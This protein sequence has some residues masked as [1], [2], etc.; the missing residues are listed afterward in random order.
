[1]RQTCGVTID[2]YQQHDAIGLAEFV[3]RGAVTPTELL[4]LAV[5]RKE[6]VNSA[7]NAVSTSLTDF[8][9]QAINTGLPSGPFHGV[10]LLLKDQVDL[11]GQPTRRA[12]KLLTETVPHQDS[13]V[14][15]RL[16][17]AGFVIF[18]KTNMPELGLSVTTEPK[19]TGPTLNPWNRE[20]SPGGSSGG[21]AAAVAAG[22]CPAATGTDGGGSIR[23]PAS[24]CAV[25]GLKP[26][27]GR[28]PYGPDHGEGWGGM[29]SHGVVSRS[30]RDTAAMLD[31]LSGPAIGDPYYLESTPGTF[32]HATRM[33]PGKLRIGV[34]IDPPSG[35]LVGK[36]CRDAVDD[37]VRLLEGLGHET[38]PTRYP[39][40]GAELRDAAGTIIRTKVFEGLEQLAD[41]RGT[42]LARD[43]VEAA[44]WMIHSAGK[45]TSGRTYAEAI[46]TIHRIGR[47]MGEFMERYD[48]ILSPTLAEPP[49]KLGILNSETTDGRALFDRMREFSP[50]C[51]LFN[52]T[53]QPA[54]SVPLYWG[55]KNLPIGVQFAGKFG[56]EV[57][58][59]KLA[60]QLEA[61]RPWWQRYQWLRLD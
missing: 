24:C 13:T 49:I 41:Q 40:G 36:E 34:V 2:E 11:V 20:F 50:F 1:V 48:V 17:E 12:C 60:A 44:T 35:T 6:I 18:G 10:P 5:Q 32:L 38:E 37:A 51:N 9:G 39:I 61:A 30:V 8:A 43:D 55:T 3:R 54:M 14:V 42:P 59:L 23:I 56:D 52:A 15:A 7:L 57:T 19:L 47:Q 58:L 26:T 31:L 4:R 45:E 46:E 22:I 28:V 33:K 25:F 21:S 53:G 29:T 16:R 27:R